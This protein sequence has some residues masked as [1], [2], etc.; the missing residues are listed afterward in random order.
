MKRGRPKGS[1]LK[2]NPRSFMM[3]IR[4]TEE[5]RFS[6]IGKAARRMGQSVSD[7]V[8]S[9]ALAAAEGVLATTS[10]DLE[11]TGK[12]ARGKHRKRRGW[13]HLKGKTQ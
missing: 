9:T 3:Q 10:E 7:F 1:G 12:G 4:C 5:E 13:L 6:I 11:L 8:R 2:E